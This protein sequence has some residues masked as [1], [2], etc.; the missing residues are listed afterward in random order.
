MQRIQGG[1]LVYLG[2]HSIAT[3]YFA[4]FLSPIPAVLPQK[5]SGVSA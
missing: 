1:V 2:K 3:H 5:V 4:H